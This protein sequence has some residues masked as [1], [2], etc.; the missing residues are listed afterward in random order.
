MSHRPSA[1]RIRPDAVTVVIS[2]FFG[3]GFFPIAPATF[4]SAVLTIGLGLAG[5]ASA[6]LRVIL[7][8]AVSAI[9]VWAATHTE[10]RYGHDASVIV[11][12]E[13]AGMLLSVLL[14]PWDWLHLIP[15]FFLFRAMDILK[16]PPV[17]QLQSLP[18]GWGVMIDDL[19]A[20]AYTLLLLLLGGLLIPG[21]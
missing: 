8:V 10:R 3:C 2:S 21:F 17:Y 19:G 7:V 4:A 11:I 6:I 13:I 14:I 16:P 15:A 1:S 5:G 20:G 18:E 9:G 12:D